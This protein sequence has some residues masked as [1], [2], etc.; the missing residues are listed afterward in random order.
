MYLTSK[1]VLREKDNINDGIGMPDW[2]LSIALLLSWLTIFLVIIRG[3]RSTGKAA[4]FLA[5]FPYVVLIVLFVR[6]VTLNGS[7][8]G[9][10]YFITPTWEKLL[11]PS[12]WY[13][14]VAQC[15]FSL[16]ICFGAVPMFASYNKFH[17]DVYRL[18][19]AYI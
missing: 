17:Y 7:V 14:A 1:E 16:T 3:V 19:Y 13:Y 2:R 4:Y 12:I 6:A 15:F 10:L 8:A 18:V 9:I 5:I 11:T